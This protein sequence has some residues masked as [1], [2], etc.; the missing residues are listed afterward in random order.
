MKKSV[1][2]ALL[3]IALLPYITIGLLYAILGPN[4]STKDP[5][6]VTLGVL[7]FLSIPFQ[8]IFYISN[9][10]RNRTVAREQRAFWVV[11]LFFG[12]IA[13]F[14]FYWYL[15]IWKDK[16]VEKVPGQTMAPTVT[17]HVE[18]R[19]VK[20]KALSYKLIVLFLNLLPWILGV[21]AFFLFLYG[22]LY[23]PYSN[24]YYV[25]AILAFIALI[26]VTGFSIVEMYRD[27]RVARN[28]RALWAVVLIAGAPLSFFI[29]WYLYIWRDSQRVTQTSLE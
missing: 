10:F 1:K 18:E 29:Y 15:H 17:N 22:P 5:F 20:K 24:T 14:P 13:V 28:L 8:W 21:S 16:D 11:L 26:C 3:I 2:I 4:G 7:M 9:V 12:H 6:L 23:G 19:V 27:K 25:L